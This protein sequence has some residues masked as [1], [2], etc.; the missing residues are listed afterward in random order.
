VSRVPVHP[1]SGPPE[2]RRDWLA[3]IDEDS[4]VLASSSCPCCIGR[5]EMQVKLVRLLRERR[6]A[7]VFVELADDTHLAT[8]ARVLG[9][10]PLAQYVEAGRAVRLPEQRALDPAAL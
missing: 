2:A 6:P 4:A 10:W 8:F 3:R 1:V 7:R 9:E 5:V